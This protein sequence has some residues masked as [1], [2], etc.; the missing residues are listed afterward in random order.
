M[1]V[2]ANAAYFVCLAFSHW[3]AIG[4]P[5]YLITTSSAAIP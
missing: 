1:Y 3:L 4:S 2:V 5:D